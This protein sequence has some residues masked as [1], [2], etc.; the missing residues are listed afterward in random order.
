[1]ETT[2]ETTTIER[3]VEIAASPER[4]WQFLADPDKPI[5]WMGQTASFDPRP[6]GLYLIPGSAATCREQR[7]WLHPPCGQARPAG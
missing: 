3:V 5:L 1:M 7:V 2:A 6:G 4:V